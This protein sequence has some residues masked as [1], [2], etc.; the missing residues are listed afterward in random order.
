MAFLHRVLPIVAACS[1]LPSRT[2]IGEPPTSPPTL[3]PQSEPVDFDAEILPLLKQ[4]CLACHHAKQPE[5]G[6]NLESRDAILAGSD[7]GPVVSPGAQQESLL[8]AR[9]TGVEEPKMP[10]E[11]NAVGA[12]PLSPEQV[13]LLERWI[14]EGAQPGRGSPEASIAWQPLA[15]RSQPIQAVAAAVTGQYLVAGRGNAAVV[16]DRYTQAE[17]ARLV[18]PLV[19]ETL[20]QPAA[21]LDLVQSIAIAPDGQQIATGGYRT[22]KLWRP[23]SDPVELENSPLAR[24]VGLVARST[25]GRQ[26]AMVNAA[27]DIEIHNLPGPQ[28]PQ[29]IR[30]P[31][32]AVIGLAWN[33]PGTRLFSSDATGRIVAWQPG[34]DAP[35]AMV[36]APERLFPGLVVSEAGDLIVAVDLTRRVRL[37]RLTATDASSEQ[38][39]TLEPIELPET[40]PFTDASATT[41]VPGDEPLLAIGNESGI[42]SVVKLPQGEV[43]RTIETSSAVDALAAS[44]AGD[45]L[46]VAGRAQTT[47]LWQLATGQLLE[48]WQNDPRVETEL[49]KAQ[50][51]HTRQ[52]TLLTAWSTR[53]EE[54][55]KQAE[56]QQEA[57]AK[58]QTARNEASEQL[59]THAKT[60]SEAVVAVT[61]LETRLLA[62]QEA[63]QQ[64]A[65]EAE[66]AAKA[67]EEAKAAAEQLA[68]ELEEKKKAVAAADEA[69]VKQEELLA[70]REQA[71]AATGQ[72]TEHAKHEAARHDDRV[73]LETRR[74]S[75]LAEQQEHAKQQADASRRPPVAIAFSEHGE[76]LATAHQNGLI[77]VMTPG[78]PLATHTFDGPALAA[79]TQL[80]AS[81]QQLIVSAPGQR[82]AAWSLKTHWHLAQTIG[83]ADES[84]FSDRVGALDYAPDGHTLAVGS[85]S[86]SSFGEIKLIDAHSGHLVRD[87]GEVHSDSVLCLRFS[88]DGRQLA[89]S[90]ADKTVRLFDVATGKV[91][92]SLDGHTHH[93]LS[94]AWRD[95]L[96]LLASASADQSVK[97]WNPRTGARVR[98]ITGAEQEVIG[99]EFLHATTHLVVA[100]A[101]GHVRIVNAD[102]EQL[103]VEFDRVDDFLH[104]LTATPDGELIVAGGQQGVLHGWSAET[105]KRIERP[106]VAKTAAAV[107]PTGR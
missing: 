39:P 74:L 7:S 13:A 1:L 11:D 5:G 14:A 50:R 8:L 25:D 86:P 23:G 87:L 20:S 16:Y 54:A 79:G 27:G 6:L 38:P 46:A 18:D 4:N 81:A 102:N 36:R 29:V 107:G 53:R 49:R 28:P 10:P 31:S 42:V 70:A 80:L 96:E 84:P 93:V 89:S 99:V 104:A 63:S 52:Q 105:G 35:L 22:V 103:V 15:D 37:W 21:H 32:D 33:Q 82:A 51:N 83:T 97:L 24:A 45:L 19:T 40:S 98:S 58:A 68:A 95:D 56:Q 65:A 57:L 26:L 106:E 76:W 9:I 91:T 64:R 34:V 60:R 94:V 41:W 44:P 43:V 73:D 100:S 78:R 92:R 75:I 2:A 30:D 67:A 55:R 101:E 61:D 71:L 90:A 48:T 77:S 85:G 47:S 59:A 3:P 17:V 88:P 62:A 72:A 66:A 12:V 69:V